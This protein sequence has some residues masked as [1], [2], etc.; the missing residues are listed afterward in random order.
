MSETELTTEQVRYWFSDDADEACVLSNNERF[1]KWLAEYTKDA[2]TKAFNRYAEIIEATAEKPPCS[3]TDEEYQNM[4][5]WAQS[6]RYY[7]TIAE[8][9]IEDEETD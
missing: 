8:H 9:K 3:I 7:A 5:D 4:N 1:D 2:I 6:I